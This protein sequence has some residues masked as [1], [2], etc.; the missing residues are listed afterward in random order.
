MPG[1]QHPRL[2][3]LRLDREIGGDAAV[4]VLVLASGSSGNAAVVRSDGTT[5]LVDAGISALAIRRRM[6]AFGV[7]LTD[8]DAVML[9]HEHTD[10]TRGLEV[11]LKRHQVPVWATQG[12]WAG[13]GVRCDGGGE[14]VSGRTLD[15][16]SLQVTPVATSHDARE[17]VAL[18]LDDQRTRAAVMTDTGIVTSLLRHRLAGCQ[19]LLVEA[20][21][22]ADMLR[23]G[24]YPW[25]L[26]QR[27]ASR[28]GHLGNH[29][30]EEALAELVT[31]EL[32]GVVGMH[33][34]EQN[35]EPELVRRLLRSVV[36]PRTAVEVATRTRMVRISIA[37]NGGAEGVELEHRLA[38]EG[39]G[40]A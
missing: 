31:P 7:A 8:L 15:V 1:C 10:H 33:L 4:E 9:S 27:I 21:H 22:D 24:P 23:R 17:P 6:E 3:R 36:Q 30:I 35:N 25:P 26:K 20:N 32:A 11:L 29:Q 2:R 5:V 16:G 37:E 34:S 39:R 13:V 40:R 38:P 28:L 14:L 19:L 12:T 18:I